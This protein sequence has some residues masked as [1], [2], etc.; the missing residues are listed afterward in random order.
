METQV[1]YFFISML[2]AQTP[3][4]KLSLEFQRWS[5]NLGS[6]LVVATVGPQAYKLVQKSAQRDRSIPIT[7]RPVSPVDNLEPQLRRDLHQQAQE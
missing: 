6:D 2:Y 1:I 3:V 7:I 5:S 4:Q